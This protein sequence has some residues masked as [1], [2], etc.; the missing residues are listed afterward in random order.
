[1]RIYSLCGFGNA[2]SLKD[3]T[4]DDICDVEKFMREE[5]APLMKKKSNEINYGTQMISFFGEHYAKNPAYFEFKPG[6][7]RLIMK[8]VLHVQNVINSSE[9][10]SNSVF[11]YFVQNKCVV[12]SSDMKPDCL[13]IQ[14][15][16]ERSNSCSNPFLNKLVSTAKRNE[17]RQ[18]GG[19]RYDN[20][21]K[22]IGM[23]LRIVSGP[24]VYETIQRNLQHSL[25]SLPSTN[26]YIRSFGCH[27]V[28]GVFR[29][30]ELLKFLNDR[31]LP[32][33]V[34]LSMDETRIEDEVQ[35]DS[36]TNQIVGFTLPLNRSTGLPIPLAYPA[37]NAADIMKHF[38]VSNSISSNLN[39]VM[40]QPLAINVPAFCLLAYG[41]DKRYNATDVSNQWKHM[42]KQL[43]SLGIKDLTMSSDSDPKYNA[44]MRYH[45]KLGMPSD[46]IQFVWFS[47]AAGDDGPFNFQD[48]EHIATKFRNFILRTTYNQRKLPFGRN[49]SIELKHLYFIMD[50]F[51]KDKHELTQSVLNPADKQ[52][53]KS[54]E[55]MCSVKVTNLLKMFPRCNATMHFLETIRD[56]IAAFRD[57]KLSPLQRVKKMWF[58][59]FLLRLWR[60]YILRS[61][62]YTLKYNFLT[63]YA[64]SCV[65]L[66]GHSLIQVILYLQ[67]IN[68]PE[69]FLPQ[70]FG[71]Q[72]CENIFRQM[73]SLTSTYSTI[74]NC[75][76][77]EALSR[78]SK[79][80]I[81]NDIIHSESSNFKFPR[82]EVKNKTHEKVF[83]L[84]SLKEI[85]EAV[86]ECAADAIE[87]AQILNLV[88]ED[89]LLDEE[90][91]ACK[92]N[93][94]SLPRNVEEDPKENININPIKISDLNGL[95]L[96]NFSASKQVVDESGPYVELRFENNIKR[97]VVRKSSLVWLLRK[98]KQRLS[99]DRLRR[100]QCKTKMYHADH[101]DYTANVEKTMRSRK[102]YKRKKV[103]IYPFKKNLR[104]KKM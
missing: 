54:V 20:D 36:K 4:I 11:K 18:K 83:P 49:N 62:S 43:A 41:T 32:L 10:N 87:I 24:F 79:I 7:K 66:N 47:S 8:L 5:W 100:V 103:L 76:T 35:Y 29:S 60:R 90:L 45:S 12:E 55:R 50:K 75:S 53:F 61:P 6:H 31:K 63:M 30:H 48:P 13:K 96:K 40:A 77:K 80:E 27:I 16:S 73:R 94:N 70:L 28:E 33:V 71:S 51:R 84:P 67:K 85:V 101:A 42:S 99:S 65:E 56:V 78:L 81:Q 39:V 89:D 14:K 93:P 37:R 82:N 22:S 91:F 46:L 38:S 68:H 21:S 15:P 104:S 102:V 23:Y 95:T 1:M 57:K 86:E 74:A 25:P 59:I 34:C 19:Y 17:N 98:D 97:T 88:T 58:R 2:I 3:C 44:A 9:A 92:I 52:N 72:Q 26:R 69:L 64:Y